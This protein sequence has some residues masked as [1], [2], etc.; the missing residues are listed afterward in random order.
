MCCLWGSINQNL[1]IW[2][3]SYKVISMHSTSTKLVFFF[4]YLKLNGS[5]RIAKSLELCQMHVK[6]LR[7]QLKEWKMQLVMD[8]QN[9]LIYFACLTPFTTNYILC[10]LYHLPS[11]QWFHYSMRINLQRLKTCL[12]QKFLHSE[13]NVSFFGQRSEM[14]HS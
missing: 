6:I 3:I 7:F 8:K 9:V 11:S 5:M 1:F 12:Q 2:H 13:H 4:C 10:V 14:L